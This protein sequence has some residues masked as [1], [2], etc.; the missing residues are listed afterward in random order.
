MLGNKQYTEA[1]TQLNKAIQID[2]DG[3]QAYN[4]IAIV[5]LYYLHQP[6]QAFEHYRS[7]VAKGGVAKLHVLCEHVPGWLAIS[8]GSAGFDSSDGA[9]SFGNAAVTEAKKNKSD[10]VKFGKGRQTFHIRL[11][12]GQNYNFE[13]GSQDAGPEVDFI[14]SIIGP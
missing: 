14:L 5:E 4:S 12:N 3:Y 6:A 8:R 1:Q 10:I 7:A 13:P 2:P 11:S 9:H